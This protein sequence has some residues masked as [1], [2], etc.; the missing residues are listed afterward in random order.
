MPER[1]YLCLRTSVTYVPS[2]YTS[3]GRA[4]RGVQDSDLR[5]H[6]CATGAW[7]IAS[8]ARAGGCVVERGCPAMR[9]PPRNS[10]GYREKEGSMRA[11]ERL[12]RCNNPVS[13]TRLPPSWLPTP[14]QPRGGSRLWEM[15]PL[16]DS[17]TSLLAINSLASL[18]NCRL[19][20]SKFRE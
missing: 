14:Q 11:S 8:E 19:G 18:S 15:E 3:R 4:R 1:C 12:P 6:G 9:C 7:G 17:A 13:I 16:A 20:N 2:L 10:G 5:A